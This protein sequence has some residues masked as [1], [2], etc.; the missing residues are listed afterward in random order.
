M[1]FFDKYTG[2]LRTMRINY[3]LYNLLHYKHLEHNKKLYKQYGVKRSIFRSIS[4]KYFKGL[5]GEQSWLDLPNANEKLQA[6]IGELEQFAPQVKEQILSWPDTGFLRLDKFFS[7]EQVEAL[8]TEIDRLQEEGKIATNYT[9]RK[10]VM[11]YRHSPKVREMILDER[12]MKVLNFIMGREV[13][14]FQTLNFIKGS[15]QKAHSDSVHMTTHPLGYLTAAWIALE[16]TNEDNGPLFYYPSS[17][18][19]PYFFNEDFGSEG[20]WMRIGSNPNKQYEEA[21]SKLIEEKGLKPIQ[22]HAKKGDVFVW[23]ANLL[24]GGMPQNN[25]ELTRKSMVAHYF[26][27]GAICYHEISQRPAIIEPISL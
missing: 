7:D 22:L 13:I 9:G 25:Q 5:K 10:I 21:V 1:R 23:H 2:F 3:V 17:H 18:K 15:E 16:D 4:G 24:H 14:P 27:E 11:A 12:L 6:R 19:F 8:N 20:N 26:C